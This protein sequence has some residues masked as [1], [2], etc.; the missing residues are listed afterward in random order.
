MCTSQHHPDHLPG[1]D[2][3]QDRPD[4]PA[5]LGR[6]ALL[7]AAAV[8]GVAAV[9]TATYEQFLAPP[10]AAVSAP[11]VH[12]CDAWRADAPRADLTT[13]QYR[14]TWIVVHHTTYPN[15]DD[16][17]RSAAFARARQIQQD[18]FARGWIDSGQQFTISRGGHVMEGRHGSLA[19]LRGG[20]SFVHGAQAAGHNAE[21]IGIEN[22]GLYTAALPTDPQW[23]SLVTFLAYCCQQYRVSVDNIV[24]H[25]R[26][27]AT[28]CPGDL[29]HANLGTL[30]E[31]VQTVL[32]GGPVSP[33][34]EDPETPP[35]D[36]NSWA[37]LK[38]GTSGYRVTTLQ[39]LLRRHGHDVAADGDFG[40]L[41]REAVI[42]FQGS[43]GLA[44][45]GVVGPKTWPELVVLARRGDTGDQVRAVQAGLAGRGRTVAVDGAFGPATE[46]AVKAFQQSRALA[47]DGV[48]GPITWSSLMARG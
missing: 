27:S 31:H 24:G 22:D 21:S 3:P 33:P 43:A 30:R 13:H 26:L 47:V 8:G 9:T 37:V 42:A 34:P 48:V 7:G 32:D 5:R 38:Q 12:G 10:A 44:T 19:A 39:Y 28:E 35:V 40:P 23:K 14:P 1:P 46:A 25:R 18:H 4:A 45:D 15:T 29:F 16:L 41:T 2:H 20:T 36:E 17:S 11:Q 6:R